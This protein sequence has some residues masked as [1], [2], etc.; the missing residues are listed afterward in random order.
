[1]WQFSHYYVLYIVAVN[2]VRLIERKFYKDISRIYNIWEKDC[3]TDLE[4]GKTVIGIY[5][6]KSIYIGYIGYTQDL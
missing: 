1:M 5:R 2:A 6:V 3:L 4:Q